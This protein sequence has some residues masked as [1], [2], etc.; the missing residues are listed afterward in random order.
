MLS[1]TSI[2]LSRLS[3]GEVAVGL[4]LDCDGSLSRLSGGEGRPSTISR[5]AAISQP[6]VRRGSRLRGDTATARCSLSRLSG[7]EGRLPVAAAA[8]DILSAACPAGKIS[9][10]IGAVGHDVSQPPV[11]RGRSRRSRCRSRFSQPPVRRG[12]RSRARPLPAASLSR[13]SGGEVSCLGGY[14]I[15]IKRLALRQ[16]IA[17]SF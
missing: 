17:E 7:G 8:R 11:R 14:A 5:R 9:D 3:G 15:G 4:G 10:R 16:P 1:Q 6:P 2:S 13:L 12:R